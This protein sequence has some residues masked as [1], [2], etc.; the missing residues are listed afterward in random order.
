M[1]C[2][3]W[4]I[5][6]ILF[7][8]EVAVASRGGSN[9]RFLKAGYEDVF[10]IGFSGKNAGV[11]S[12][13]T[14]DALDDYIELGPPP[15]CD[16]CRITFG[17]V[18]GCSSLAR[19]RYSGN[20]IFLWHEL[21][22]QQ[23]FEASIGS[24]QESISSIRFDDDLLRDSWGAS[25]FGIM[26]MC[27]FAVF[28]TH[29]EDH[30][31]FDDG[32]SVS[33]A[34]HNIRLCGPGLLAQLR[35]TQ[36]LARRALPSRLESAR[37]LLSLA[38]ACFGNS[39]ESLLRAGAVWSF[40]KDVFSEMSA[41]EQHSEITASLLSFENPNHAAFYLP[42]SRVREKADIPAGMES[43]LIL[44]VEY[45]N[46]DSFGMLEF[47]AF[48]GSLHNI[49]LLND[50]SNRANEYYSGNRNG[51]YKPS[52]SQALQWFDWECS[53]DNGLE[54]EFVPARVFSL[55]SW[56]VGSF[57]PNRSNWHA[58]PS[59][60][61]SC[62]LSSQ[63]G[64]RNSTVPL[65]SFVVVNVSLRVQQHPEVH[66][67]TAVKIVARNRPALS[68]DGESHRPTI[69]LCTQPLYGAQFLEHRFPGSIEQWITHHLSLGVDL[70][71]L[72]D[73]DGSFGP[74]VDVEGDTRLRYFPKWSHS[75][76][77]AYGS[78]VDQG[79]CMYCSEFLAYDH[80]LYQMKAVQIDWF[81]TVHAPDAFLKPSG[82]MSLR[83]LVSVQHPS[84][85]SL[86][87][88]PIS[89]FKCFSTPTAPRNE[90]N[91]ISILSQFL[92]RDADMGKPVSLGEPLS[93]VCATLY[94]DRHSAKP[95]H[96]G[97]W[98]SI[99]LDPAQWRLHHYRD[100][101]E[102]R[103]QCST[104]HREVRKCV[105]DGTATIRDQSLL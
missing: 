82:T 19:S 34:G 69:G 67:N 84:I 103:H 31:N 42:R 83:D 16:I 6:N 53:L 52:V 15:S 20:D 18:L 78:L 9:Y 85:L 32:N 81:L 13:Q 74:F 38:F 104:D 17:L 40:L 80:C 63:V 101:F 71:V 49:R 105:D 5:V 8:F 1:V 4:R 11:I 57:E 61:I 46:T 36:L 72:Y 44:G 45:I 89:F 3:H 59:V 102:N 100:V 88:K 79:H 24:V 86:V 73:Q 37:S 35:R 28:G 29:A 47:A 99:G 66:I 48:G 95:R 68:A 56:A 50:S 27:S 30:M 60:R 22:L 26:S 62:P 21:P 7:V 33:H 43:V 92:C 64:S 76:S 96:P 55:A 91:S 65:S 75:I 93:R 54:K 10:Q 98:R 39:W 25:F 87:F 97:R 94:N 2:S 23:Q 58:S 51:Y 12:L 70:F 90:S 41:F 14:R 77:D